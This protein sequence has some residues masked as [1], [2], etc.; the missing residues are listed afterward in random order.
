MHFFLILIIKQCSTIP[1]TSPDLQVVVR[2]LLVFHAFWIVNVGFCSCISAQKSFSNELEEKK[3][4]SSRNFGLSFQL[5]YN[6]VMT[7]ER[8]LLL[9]I[10]AYI[11]IAQLTQIQRNVFRFYRVINKLCIRISLI[12]TIFVLLCLNNKLNFAFKLKYVNKFLFIFVERYLT[13]DLNF[14]RIYIQFVT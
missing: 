1:G 2:Q 10:N 3:F 7:Y 4:W 12:C 14:K 9:Q 5:F 8:L 13:M 11:L 6:Y